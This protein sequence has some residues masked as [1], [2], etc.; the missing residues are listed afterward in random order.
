MNSF[1]NN[2]CVSDLTD[3]SDL[4][5]CG[6][7]EDI[8]GNLHNDL[9]KL[10][11]D[12]LKDK[13][14]EL[15]LSGI[16]KLNK[17]DII[18]ILKTE[19]L[20]II[21]ILNTKTKDELKLLGKLCDVKKIS[22]SKKDYIVYHI[23]LYHANNMIFKC[24]TINQILKPLDP[25]ICETNKEKNKRNE[26]TR[27]II[28]EEET[29]RIIIE[30][31]TRKQI[32]KEEE[33]RKQIIEEETRQQIIKEEEIK[34]IIKEEKKLKKQSIPKNVKTG[35][36]NKYIGD[37]IIKHKCL[38]C[39]TLTITITNFEVGHVISEKDGGTHEINNLRPIC[40]PCNH[41]MGTENM[42]DFT[43]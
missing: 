26:E 19:F 9:N 34:Q 32:I 31:E 3:N 24:V 20:K 13:Y 35:I 41:A 1:D 16:S 39:K 29:R 18:H 42:I 21:P 17:P 7:V 43:F 8:I 15:G 23:L 37:D 22:T 33:T 30:E 40:S 4:T 11:M 12:V 38:C 2:S 27:R 14:K 28:I 25:S 36:W 6:S 10:N 5:G